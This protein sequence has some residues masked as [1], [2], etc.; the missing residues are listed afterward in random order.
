MLYIHIGLEVMLKLLGGPFPYCTRFKGK[1]EWH[2][3]DQEDGNCTNALMTLYSS[4][5]QKD[6]S[7]VSCPACDGDNFNLVT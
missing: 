5:V 1:K 7:H 4:K 3:V 2:Y 6:N